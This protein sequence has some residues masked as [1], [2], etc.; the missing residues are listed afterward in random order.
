[1][2]VTPMAPV[3]QLTSSLP[4]L[5]STQPLR[6]GYAL[7]TATM[8]LPSPRFHPPPHGWNNMETLILSPARSHPTLLLLKQCKATA[9]TLQLLQPQPLTPPLM[10]QCRMP[11]LRHPFNNHSPPTHRVSSL[12]RQFAANNKILK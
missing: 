1:M 3:I 12:H 9:T 7:T 5:A 8:L 6:I 11:Q 2:L 10:Q 4:T